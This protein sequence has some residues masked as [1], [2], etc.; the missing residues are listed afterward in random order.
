MVY[1][2]CR[3]G[4]REGN[5]GDRQFRLRY[6]RNGRQLTKVNDPTPAIKALDI[7][8]LSVEWP[9]R[10]VNSWKGFRDTGRPSAAAAAGNHRS[11]IRP[12]LKPLVW[13]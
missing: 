4:R 3:S 11:P 2:A 9:Q 1:A 7:L 12:R 10:L 5:P 13:P 8:N 6:R